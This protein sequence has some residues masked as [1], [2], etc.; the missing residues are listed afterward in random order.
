ML[1]SLDWCSCDEVFNTNLFLQSEP[2]DVGAYAKKQT[3]SLISNLRGPG[4]SGWYIMISWSGLLGNP[5]LAAIANHAVSNA[6]TSGQA[7]AAVGK[8]A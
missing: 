8:P 4:E 2:G 1:P 7:A 3:S 6:V 5:K